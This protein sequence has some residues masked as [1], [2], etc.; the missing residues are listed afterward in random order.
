MKRF[1]TLTCV[2]FLNVFV[3]AQTDEGS[4]KDLVKLSLEELMNIR[5]VTSTGESQKASEAPSIMVVITKE[6][7]EQR[8]YEQ[9]DDALRDV[10]GIDLIHT[11]QAHDPQSG[12]WCIDRKRP[13]ATL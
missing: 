13:Y 11:T 4:T 5:V 8:G 9:L 7:I 10:P 1:I 12:A 3:F 6:Q 2:L